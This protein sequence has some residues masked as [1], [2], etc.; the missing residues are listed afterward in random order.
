M[1]SVG[2]RELKEQ[3][4]QIIKQVR[5]QGAMIEVTYHGQAVARIIPMTSPTPNESQMGALQVG[6]KISA[7]YSDPMAAARASWASWRLSK[8]ADFFEYWGLNPAQ[9]VAIGILLIL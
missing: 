6:D 1:I 7:N 9:I 5:E 2:V 8:P 4:S 3:T